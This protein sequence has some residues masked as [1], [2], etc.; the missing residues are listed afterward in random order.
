MESLTPRELYTPKI[1]PMEQ[2]VLFLPQT[3]FNIIMHKITHTH[4]F[5]FIVTWPLYWISFL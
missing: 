2:N 3:E 4:N 1:N 5:N